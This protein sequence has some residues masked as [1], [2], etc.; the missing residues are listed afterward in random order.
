[1]IYYKTMKHNLEFLIINFYSIF[2]ELISNIETFNHLLKILNFK[3]KIIFLSLFL[4]LTSYF[5][6]LPISFAQSTPP[7]SGN[8]RLMDFGF[9]AGGTATSS[10]P[11]YSLFGTLGQVDQG[12]P[13]SSNY[14]IGAGLEYTL[15]A[16]VAAAPTFTNPSNWYNKLH[17]VINKG[18]NDPQD[19]EYAI[20][21]AS[22]SGQF[23]Y[24]QNDN[25]VGNDLGNEDWQTYS[26]WG[27]A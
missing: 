8:Y 11:N 19:T 3:L 15:Q 24:V 13:S 21:I 18:G 6:L 17:L 25:T 23:Q 7:T 2:K 16:S 26:S 1:M 20:R 14:F 4:L 9:G 22:G 27:S 5:L 10:S 12:S